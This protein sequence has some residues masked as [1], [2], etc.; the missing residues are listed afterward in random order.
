MIVAQ[1]VRTSLP[2]IT[3]NPIYRPPGEMAA[4]R[5]PPRRA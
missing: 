4:A 5:D 1:L 3:E 2:R